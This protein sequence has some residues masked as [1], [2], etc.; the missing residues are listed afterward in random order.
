[1]QLRELPMQSGSVPR[2]RGARELRLREAV[3]L[4]ELWVFL[5]RPSVAVPE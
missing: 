3:R 5:R 2:E 1:L 4:C